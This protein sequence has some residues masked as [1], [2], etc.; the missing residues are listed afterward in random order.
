MRIIKNTLL[1][2]LLLTLILSGCTS[3]S[4]PKVKN[5]SKPYTLSPFSMNE[6]VTP[7]L[8]GGAESSVR[9]PQPL[10]LAE[11]RAKYSFTFLLHGPPAPRRIAFAEL[12]AQNIEIVTI[13]DLL[14][15]PAYR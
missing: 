14:H 15:K 8:A 7:D 3:P 2:P 13:P 10:T 4:A 11:L 9:K 6:S 12:S 5:Y 1:L